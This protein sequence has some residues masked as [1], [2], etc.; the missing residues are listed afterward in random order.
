MKLPLSFYRQDDVVDLAKKLLGKF[1]FS[2]IEGEITGGMI[3]ET[4]S[5]KGVEDKA[6]HAYNGRYT[7]RTKT[8]YEEGGVTYVY[9]CYGMH[10]LLNVVTSKKNIPHAV[11]IRAIEPTVGAHVM[12]RRRKRSKVEPSLTSGPGA[13]AQA[14]GVDKKLNNVKLTGSIIWIEDKNFVV[15]DHD[16]IKSPRVGVSYSEEHALLPW[17]FRIK[18][19]HWTSRAK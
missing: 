11:L 17:R 3:V 14:L 18:G 7:E 16:I 4:E 6:S 2:K 15:E 5:Y 19:N 12:L 9:F 8:M 10:Y 1:I 13:L